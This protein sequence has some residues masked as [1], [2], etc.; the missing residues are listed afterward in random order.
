MPSWV[1]KFVHPWWQQA[2]MCTMR[3]SCGLNQTLSGGV[4]NWTL[5][6]CT[7][8]RRQRGLS[9][10]ARVWAAPE[11]SCSRR[12]FSSPRTQTR[13]RGTPSSRCSLPGDDGNVCAR[14]INLMFYIR[15]D[16]KREKPLFKEKDKIF[17]LIEMTKWPPF[18]RKLWALRATIRVWSGWATSAKITS[19]IPDSETK[20]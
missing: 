9:R 7:L 16:H 17:T 13:L 1:Q 14:I 15:T 6:T 18:L 2:S 12:P 8:L 11:A 5:L 19:T 3:P 10:M 4:N 20:H